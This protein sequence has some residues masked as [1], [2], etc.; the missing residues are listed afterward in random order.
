M[1]HD[2]DGVRPVAMAAVIDWP[3]RSLLGSMYALS[4][5]PFSPGAEGTSEVYV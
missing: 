2:E 1:E 4:L 5:S 3:L